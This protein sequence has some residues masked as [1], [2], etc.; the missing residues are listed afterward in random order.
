VAWAASLLDGLRPWLAGL[1][2]GRLGCSLPWPTGNGTLVLPILS[3]MLV[4]KADFW[5]KNG[6]VFQYNV[7]LYVLADFPHMGS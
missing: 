4:N 2:V 3:L 1:N 6:T 5:G 7:P